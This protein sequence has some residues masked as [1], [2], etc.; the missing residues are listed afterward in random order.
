MHVMI[1]PRI[2]NVSFDGCVLGKNKTSEEECAAGL[3]VELPLTLLSYSVV[4]ELHHPHT[5]EAIRV[6]YLSKLQTMKFELTDA[7]QQLKKQILSIL[8]GN[9]KPENMMAD[10]MHVFEAQK[11]GNYFVTLDEGILKKADDIKELCGLNIIRPLKLK[12]VLE[13]WRKKGENQ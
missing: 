3:Y 11:Y 5:P 13:D 7:E 4:K 8:A 12:V 9:G 6:V 10:A 1:D 2:T